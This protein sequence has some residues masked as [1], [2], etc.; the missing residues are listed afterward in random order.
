MKTLS[1][2]GM[3]V[4]FLMLGSVVLCGFW[5]RSHGVDPEGVKFHGMLGLATVA[6]TGVTMVLQYLAAR[7]V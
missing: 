5:I 6:V 7:S 4:S 1:L 3:I 2:I